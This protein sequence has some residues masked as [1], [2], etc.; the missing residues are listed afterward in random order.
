LED[1]HAGIHDEEQFRV[2]PFFWVVRELSFHLFP[3]LGGG[4][5]LMIKSDDRRRRRKEK[6]TR[7]DV[8]RDLAER[9][10]GQ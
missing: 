8:V 6:K 2:M 10:G 1:I 3:I 9:N 7:L 4:P 5:I